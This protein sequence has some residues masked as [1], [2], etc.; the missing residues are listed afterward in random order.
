MHRSAVWVP[1][2]FPVALAA[3]GHGAATA[4]TDFEL[5]DGRILVESRVGDIQ[6]KAF[7]DSG[8]QANGINEGF[9]DA[10]QLRLRKG[11]SVT[12]VGANERVERTTYLDVS[13]TLFGA[14]G[15]LSNLVGYTASAADEQL[16]LGAPFLEQSIY[17]FDYPN[18]RMRVIGRDRLDLKSLANVEA[19]RDR[20]SGELVVKIRLNGEKDV[21]LLVDTGNAGGIAL[22]R[23][24]ALRRN[25]LDRY[26]TEAVE[27]QGVHGSSTWE[28]FTLP[29]LM[30]GPIEVRDPIIK[31]PSDRSDVAM[32]QRDV[33][34]GSRIGRRR[35]SHGGVLG[36][37]V[38]R[39][40]ILT[41]D[42]K[43]G[44]MHIALPAERMRRASQRSAS[45]SRG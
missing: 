3:G 8:S 18:R 23:G 11:R 39:H 40:F 26:P 19:K 38:L 6:G 34:V 42:Y 28:Q 27:I 4:W 30:I 12:M 37:D 15:R 7:I 2:L 25:W 24:V 29:T 20:L 5:K 35:S 41:I 21:W 31:V 9:L 22:D 1:F 43:L 44:R 32:F 33:V 16:L 14:S 10:H 17:Q 13:V 45:P 36:F